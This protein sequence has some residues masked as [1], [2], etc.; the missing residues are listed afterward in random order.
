MT[1]LEKALSAANGVA[2][3]H[4]IGGAVVDAPAAR[5][6]VDPGRAAAFAEAPDGAGG[7]VDAA[8]AAARRALS[9]SWGRMKPVERGRLLSAVAR[10]LTDDQER[11]ALVE[12]LNMGKPLRQSRGDVATAA[13][14][15]EYYAGVADKLEGETIPLGPGLMAWTEREP[16]GVVAQIVP[17]N[18][19]LAMLARGL[20][21][22]LA[23]GCT[24]VI[25][26]AE[27]T[28]LTA[29]MLADVLAEA[30]LPA[31]VVNVVL[32]PGS[33]GAILA[34]HTGVAHITFTGSV[35]TGKAVMTAAATHLA[36]VTLEL[37]GKSPVVVLDD[38]DLDAAAEGVVRGIVT[39][40][41]QVC[42][43]GSRV[44]ADRRIASALIERV[45]ARL[46]K[47]SLGHGLDDPDV[48]PLASQTQHQRVAAA[49]ERAVA[50][51]DRI[52]CGGAASTGPGYFMRPVVLSTVPES[53]LAQDEVFGPVL[54]VLEVDDLAEAVRVAN[55]SPYG[56]VAGIYSRDIDRAL[57]FARA[58]EVGQVFVNR[59]LAGG[60]ETPV[61]GVK[62]SGFGREKGLRGLDAYLRT[63]C[64]T[65]SFHEA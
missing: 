51:G 65:V 10:R 16:V 11:F 40:A 9:A 46:A 58:A 14:F 53:P 19:P 50:G 29:L 26:P 24:A 21:P 17:W 18:A 57:A 47:L 5:A 31:G 54:A 27:T 30:G 34:A 28:P 4:R 45:S 52:L 6:L 20:A 25:K 41:G 15:F 7:E 60:V 37:G 36:T 59:Y 2:L 63:K 44:I 56:L 23:A 49:V 22:S 1:M 48:G 62:N 38:A 12:T 35:A 3:A 42:A 33:T 13:R 32:G 55:D 61:G 43:A 64:T 39:N 8:V